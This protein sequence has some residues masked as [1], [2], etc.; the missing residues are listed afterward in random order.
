VTP[1]PSPAPRAL[2]V[3]SF[4]IRNGRAL[5]GRNSWWCRRRATA[6]A[7]AGLGA[8]VVGLQEAFGFQLRWL[9]GQLVGV[10]AV[11]V[12][13]DDGRRGEHSPIVAR[14]ATVRTLSDRTRWFGATPDTVGTRLPEAR[15]PRIATVAELEVVATGAHVQVVCTHLD[16]SDRGRRLTS[17]EQLVTWLDPSL[18]RVIVG[19]LNARPGAPELEPLLAAGYRHALPADAGGT[20]HDFT[21][22]TDGKRIDHILVSADIEVVDAHVEHPRPFGRLP[23]DHWPVVADLLIP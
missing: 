22:R 11:V 6:A 2:R 8:D 21:G 15:F 9:L 10:A 20:N 1:A 23:S 4:N 18:P 7:I 17:A 16:A 13:R 5:D 19:D 14:T 12:G 3:A